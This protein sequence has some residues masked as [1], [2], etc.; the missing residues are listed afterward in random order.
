MV[1]RTKVLPVDL[2]MSKLG[3]TYIDVKPSLKNLTT[4]F[5]R[6]PEKQDD[7]CDLLIIIVSLL[8]QILCYV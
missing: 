8:L 3:D 1:S 2:K 7:V 4:N 5:G 6:I